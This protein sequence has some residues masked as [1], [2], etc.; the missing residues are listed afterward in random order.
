LIVAHDITKMNQ[1]GEALQPLEL[2]FAVRMG[3]IMT[4]QCYITKG[5][6]RAYRQDVVIQSSIPS[7]ASAH[8]R[9]PAIRVDPS[10]THPGGRDEWT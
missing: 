9:R 10:E 3:S 5:S 7:T 8:L 1:I 4:E 6:L 2:E